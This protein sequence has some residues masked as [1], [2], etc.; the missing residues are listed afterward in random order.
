MKVLFALLLSFSTPLLALG[1]E[2]SPQP[3]WLIDAPTAGLLP[4]GSFN[5][6]FRFYEQNGLLA[7]FEI[8]VFNQ[9]MIGFSFGGQDI[10][11][12]EAVKWNP[13]VEFSARIRVIDEGISSPAVAAGYQSQGPGAYS[14]ADSLKRYATK[15]KGL[16]VVVSKN[17]GSAMGD[18]GVHAGVNRS[19]EDAD[20]D[21]DF[22]GFVGIDKSLGQ[23]ISVV[24]EYD[25]ALNDN[26]DNTLGSG[27]GFLN[28]GGRWALSRKL[29]I[30]VDIKNIFQDGSRN[31]YPDRE[32][33][34]LFFEE[35]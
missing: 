28:L 10:V 18:V 9:A 32:L 19:L 34:I 24:A 6:D 7:Q 20:G 14:E 17:F 2:M 1:Q 15:S 35:F 29:A 30:E 33:R 27:K 3:R 13:K 21:G 8:G 11:G 25:F 16:Y 12:N 4:R 5:I 23:D 26:E 31:P 22:S